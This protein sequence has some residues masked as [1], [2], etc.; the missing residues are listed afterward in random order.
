MPAAPRLLA[1]LLLL[2][3][4]MPVAADPQRFLHDTPTRRFDI[5]HRVVRVR[6][7]FA[8]QAI[9]GR[10]TLSGSALDTLSSLVLDARELSVASAT[11]SVRGPLPF[12][13]D[14]E[15]LTLR[16][17][18]PLARGERAAVTIVYTTRPRSGLYWVVPDADHPGR[19]PEVWSS[20]R[21]WR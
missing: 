2:S 19:R 21:R 6:F 1:A 4:A 20:T 12:A 7:D 14:D 17:P 13:S 18:A 5:E 3:L 9:E 15:H 10:V 11:D 8:K 16:F